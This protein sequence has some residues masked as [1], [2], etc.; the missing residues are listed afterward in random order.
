MQ[1]YVVNKYLWKKQHEEGRESR[2]KRGSERAGEKME[3]RVGE[4]RRKGGSKEKVTV[5]F[6]VISSQ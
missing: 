6:S 5:Y 2:R 4:K 1:S 3:G